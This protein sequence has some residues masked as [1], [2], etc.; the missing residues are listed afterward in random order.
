MHH[1]VAALDQLNPHPLRQKAVLEVGGVVHA[2]GEQHH[3]RLG[4]RA[5]RR[6]GLQSL[7]QLAR[8]IVHRAD[9]QAREHMW[10]SSLHQ[11]AVL[12]DVGNARRHAQVVFQHVNLAI[13]VANQ[14]RAGN[15]APDSAGRVDAAAL[16]AVKRGGMDDLLRDDFVLQDFL[17]VVDVVDKLVEGMDALLEAALDPIP[18]FGANDARNQVEGENAFRARRISI[19]I[20]GNPHLQE[21]GF[22]RSLAPQK[23]AVSERLD[24]FKQQASFRTRL[25]VGVEHLVIETVGLIRIELHSH[26]PAPNTGCAL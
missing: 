13:A 15:V 12:Q 11:V 26:L 21:K 16:G 6:D 10:K 9:V 7:Q 17:V 20:E 22:R 8:V 4:R 3:R 1:Q 18:F 19:N 2:R 5:G 24:G 23:L 14:I 25:A